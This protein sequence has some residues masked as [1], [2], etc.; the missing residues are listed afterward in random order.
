MLTTS[1]FAYVHKN[2]EKVIF[3]KQLDI[4]ELEQYKDMFDCLQEGI[5]VIEENP[6]MDDYQLLFCNDM[7]NRIATKVLDTK[8]KNK[9][10][11]TKLLNSQ[12]LFEYKNFN[13]THKSDHSNRKSSKTDS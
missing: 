12:V 5:V 10:F 7:A 6:K 13:S 4:N 1:F 11:E 9:K 2:I 8:K 3:D